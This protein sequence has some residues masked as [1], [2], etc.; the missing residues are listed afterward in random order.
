MIINLEVFTYVSSLDVNMGCYHIGLSTR[1]KKIYTIVL[2]WGKYEY[3]KITMG[4]CIS[5]DIFQENISKLFEVF[6]IVH[7]YIY[8]VIVITNH[9]FEYHLK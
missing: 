2:P 8:N 1:N 9:G 6:D 7:E 3:R 4:V 5:P